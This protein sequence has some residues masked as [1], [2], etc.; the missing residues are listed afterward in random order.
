[1][2]GMEM[3]LIKDGRSGRVMSWAACVAGIAS[4]QAVQRAAR[5]K[6]LR[7]I[8]ISGDVPDLREEY[9]M[10]RWRNGLKG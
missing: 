10:L 4:R 9:H 2:S 1:M 8:M 3:P 7:G 5:I 6:V